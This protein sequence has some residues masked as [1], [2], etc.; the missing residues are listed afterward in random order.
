MILG[1]PVLNR[2]DLLA[3]CVAS[4]DY[5]VR[6]LVIVDNSPTGEMGEVA[7]AALPSCVESLFVTEPPA[8]LG[9]AASVNLVVSTHPAEPWWMFANA[10]TRFA[11]GDLARVAAALDGDEPRCAR[12]IDWRLFG[13]NAATVARVGLWDPNYHPCFVEDCDWEYRCHLAGVPIQ[14]LDGATTHVGSVTLGDARYARANSRSYPANLDYHRRKWGGAPRGGERFTTPFDRGGSV[15]D[16]TLDIARL[17]A[18][19]WD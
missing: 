5:P 1:I 10:D 15:A 14:Q 13:F 4:I 7:D 3:E 19:A 12:I 17:A 8:N 11:P 9:F 6:R 2:P 18:Q 16:W